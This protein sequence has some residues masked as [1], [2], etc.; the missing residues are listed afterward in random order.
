MFTIRR[1]YHK[2]EEQ[3]K[4]RVLVDRLW[5]RGISKDQKAFDEWMKDIAPGDELRKWFSHDPA[6]WP[7]FRE[8]YMDELKTKPD[9]VA[10]LKELEKTFGVVTL[11]YAAKD[12]AHNNALVL[13][14]FL[15]T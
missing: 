1:I 8:K 7:V 14:D 12:D 11:L 10:R 3:E 9:L 4:Y 2:P 5:P 6:K 13:M 15:N